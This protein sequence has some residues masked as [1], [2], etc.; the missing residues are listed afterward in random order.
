MKSI[1]DCVPQRS[2][3]NP[4]AGCSRKRHRH[5]GTNRVLRN[6]KRA[7]TSVIGRPKMPNKPNVTVRCARYRHSLH[8]DGQ[9]DDV[10]AG[11][12]KTSSLDTTQ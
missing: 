5:A 2:K 1:L 6:P 12:R 8:D 4:A 11:T 3:A 10:H 9:H 7:S